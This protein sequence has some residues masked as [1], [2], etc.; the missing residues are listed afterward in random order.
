MNKLQIWVKKF[1]KPVIV[2][3]SGAG[4]VLS[5]YPRETRMFRKEL[6][7]EFTSKSFEILQNQGSRKAVLA[8]LMQMEDQH[9]FFNAGIGSK[10]QKDGKIRVSAA[11]MDGQ[12]RKLSSV[13]NAQEIKNPSL[14]ADFLQDQRDSNV[15][16][17]GAEILRKKLGIEK[18]NLETELQRK[19][20]Q[21]RIE[22]K[23]GTVGAV[24]VD[25][26]GNVFAGTSTGGKGFEFPGRVSD[27]PTPAGNFATSEI[28]ISATGIGEKILN[29]NLCGAIAYKF[30]DGKSLYTAISE[31]MLLLPPESSNIGIIAVTCSGEVG[32]AFTSE[33]MDVG[34]MDKNAQILM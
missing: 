26:T 28:A 6:L 16:G 27:T 2:L 18:T 8:A 12:T 5:A 9:N 23:T 29:L 31:S 15:D 17:L 32:I 30:S 3:H 21:N 13:Y 22:G 11:L 10:L 4:R 19:R 14:I 25:E 33:G 7:N 34:I 24:A 1:E 20:W